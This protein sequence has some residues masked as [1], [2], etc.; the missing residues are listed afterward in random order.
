MNKYLIAVVGMCG[1][2]KSEV[3]R[4]FTEKG[5]YHIHFGEITLSEVKKRGLQV[6]EQNEKTVRE[7]IRANLGKAAYAILSSQEIMANID[8]ENIVL[9]GLYSWSEY[10]Y[11]KQHYP[12]L[13]VLAV[14]T[15][16]SIRKY[17]LSTRKIR[18]LTNSEVDL[19]DYAEIEN[20]EK[21][22]PI[23]IA[24]YY[25]T[26]NGS[27]CDLYREFGR[28]LEWIEHQEPKELSCGL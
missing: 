5:Y 25:I 24:D 18:P 10:K 6:N 21:G 3:T 14:V 16:S 13:I 4:M 28:F 11:L 22:G 17:R 8:N 12:K 19:R 1:S 27:L 7:T 23:A 2:G 20:S 9:D 26:N 15:N